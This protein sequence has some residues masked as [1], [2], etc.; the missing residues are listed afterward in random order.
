[1]LHRYAKPPRSRRSPRELAVS[2]NSKTGFAALSPSYEGSLI[3]LALHAFAQQLAIAA[4]RL[5]LFTG[6]PFRGLLVIAPE[7]HFPEYPFAL[8]L[9][10]QGSQSL[11]DVVVA[12]EDLHGC[13]SP[14][15]STIPGAAETAFLSKS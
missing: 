12:N 9:L 7:L 1:M 13:F 10:F 15:I 3:P 4:H 11:V 2:R 8:H 6:A 14:S 5:G